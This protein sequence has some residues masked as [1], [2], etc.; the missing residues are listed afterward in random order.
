VKVV[1]VW[2]PDSEPGV[3]R[4]GESA[5]LVG[6]GASSVEPNGAIKGLRRSN[7]LRKRR[8]C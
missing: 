8:A 2:T 7:G 4:V 3:T 5:H 1:D 6:D